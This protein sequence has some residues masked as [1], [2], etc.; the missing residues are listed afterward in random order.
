[1][2]ENKNIIVRRAGLVQ[3][4]DEVYAEKITNGD[5]YEGEL[6]IDTINGKAEFSVDGH[7]ECIIEHCTCIN[8]DEFTAEIINDFGAWEFEFFE[9]DADEDFLR[10]LEQNQ[11]ITNRT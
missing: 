11:R 8:V 7:L 9:E 10:W 3:T 6:K 2:N 5:I 1:M 4:E